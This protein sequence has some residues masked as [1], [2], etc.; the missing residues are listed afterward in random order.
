MGKPKHMTADRMERGERTWG[1]TIK[2]EPGGLWKV[3]DVPCRDTAKM[4][5]EVVRCAERAARESDRE[6]AEAPPAE[7]E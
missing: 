7:G 5:L 3:N 1:I 4:M 6:I 2:R